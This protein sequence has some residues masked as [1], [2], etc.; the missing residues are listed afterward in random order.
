MNR[1]AP[2]RSV[3]ARGFAL[4]EVLVA[5][6]ICAIGVLGVV[7]LQGAMTRAQTATS[8]RGDAAYLAQQLIG[9]MWVDRNNLAAY[10]T[11]SCGAACTDWRNRVASRLPGGSATVT[12]DTATGVVTIEIRWTASGEATSRFTTATTITNS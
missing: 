11:G 6:I 3:P 10:A 12:V 4:L 9:G 5:L 8:F 1:P 2:P 7:G